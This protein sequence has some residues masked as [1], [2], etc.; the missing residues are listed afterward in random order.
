MLCV[1]LLGERFVSSR[2][3]PR[4]PV[5]PVIALIVADWDERPAGS[6][7]ERFVTSN[8]KAAVRGP[9]GRGHT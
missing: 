8:E 2:L 5:R 3:G 9:A 1:R 4:M 7:G 6:A